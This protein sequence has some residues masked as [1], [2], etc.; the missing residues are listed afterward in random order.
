MRSRTGVRLAVG[1]AL[2]FALV[3]ACAG[4]RVS[5]EGPETRR[6][7]TADFHRDQLADTPTRY[8]LAACNQ[9]RGGLRQ[10]H[11]EFAHYPDLL[12]DRRL[13]R[14]IDAPSLAEGAAPKDGWGREFDYS[15]TGNGV[16]LASRGA[17][18]V[19]ATEDDIV[20]SIDDS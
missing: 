18:G 3:G 13:L 16:R 19:R 4:G 15:V 2:L 12:T 5:S 20:C 6:T 7:T 8:T 11:R 14:L 1:N 9:L 17:D 10:F